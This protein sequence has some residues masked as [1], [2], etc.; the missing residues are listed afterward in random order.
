LA[1]VYRVLKPGGR[2]LI[3]DGESSNRILPQMMKEA[4]FT[5]VEVDRKWLILSSV[6]GT[7]AKPEV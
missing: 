4:G 1:E 5:D 2:L 3:L 7:A 6:R